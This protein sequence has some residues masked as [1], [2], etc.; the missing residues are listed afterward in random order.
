MV[1]DSLMDAV[2]NELSWHLS[3]LFGGMPATEGIF[4]LHRSVLG[5]APP[6]LF[7]TGGKNFIAPSVCRVWSGFRLCYISSGRGNHYEALERVAGTH[8]V[9]RDSSGSV[10]TA[11][12]RAEKA[13]A[14]HNVG[15]ALECLAA[16]GILRP[17]DQ[18]RQLGACAASYTLRVRPQTMLTPA[19]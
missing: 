12:C 17:H 11:A 19:Q 8:R 1:G 13:W 16:L 2:Q 4:P 10:L 9:A 18:V 14:Y 6:L 5:R 7:H 15:D 3:R